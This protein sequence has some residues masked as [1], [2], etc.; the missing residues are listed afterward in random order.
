MLNQHAR[1]F[2]VAAAIAAICIVLTAAAPGFFTLENL[3]Y[4]LL[5]NMPVLIVAIGMTVVIL[6]GQIDISVGSQF[7]ICSV[8]AGLLAKTGLPTLAAGFLTCI[9]GAMLGALNGTF[10]AYVQIPSIVVT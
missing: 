2:S 6:P 9:A 3:G 5:A 8:L 10:V 7:A 1:E 4:L